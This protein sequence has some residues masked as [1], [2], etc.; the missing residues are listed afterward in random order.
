VLHAALAPLR[1]GKA[2]VL[3]GRRGRLATARLCPPG[4]ETALPARTLALPWKLTRFGAP[5]T[6]H[7][8][9]GPAAEPAVQPSPWRWGHGTRGSRTG[10]GPFSGRLGPAASQEKNLA[11]KMGDVD[12]GAVCPAQA[13]DKGTHTP[14]FRESVLPLRELARPGSGVEGKGTSA[15]VLSRPWRRGWV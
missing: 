14:W 4:R 9:Q 12:C 1:Q 2:Q 7:G 8:H 6:H 10:N 3:R 15:S 5:G 13:E 11:E